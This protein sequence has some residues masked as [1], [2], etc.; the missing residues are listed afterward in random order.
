V[1]RWALN[2]HRVRRGRPQMKRALL[3]GL[4]VELLA[5][6]G[7]KN[8]TAASATATASP[9][10]SATQTAT[11]PATRTPLAIAT[12]TC[13]PRAT[14]IPDAPCNPEVCQLEG[15]AEIGQRGRCQS[16]P[17]SGCFCDREGPTFTETPINVCPESTPTPATPPPTC[18]PTLGIT[19]YCATHCEPCPTI[20]AG[21]NAEACRDCIDNPVCRPEEICVPGNLANPGCCSCATPTARN[22]PN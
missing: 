9:V 17:D 19:S 21:C 16:D 10:S 14:A 6:C 7:G 3:I 12:F 18:V 11:P 1:T 8:D 22:V 2:P 5:G 4:A 20:R 15:C 13:V